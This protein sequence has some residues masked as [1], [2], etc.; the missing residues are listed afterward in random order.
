MAKYP[1]FYEFLD[2]GLVCRAN[3]VRES[4]SDK[5]MAGRIAN[6]SVLDR[7]GRPDVGTRMLHGCAAQCRG[8]RRDGRRREAG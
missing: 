5:P 6:T 3:N 7:Q 2:T 4:A 1:A 8:Q